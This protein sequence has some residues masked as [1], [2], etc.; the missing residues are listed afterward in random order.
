M[1]DN[2]KLSESPPT[3]NQEQEKDF[4]DYP[5]VKTYGADLF[6]R[7]ST[8]EDFDDCSEQLKLGN[9]PLPATK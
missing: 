3:K 1:I 6:Q 2:Y 5:A 4:Y 8:D 9:S 7:Y